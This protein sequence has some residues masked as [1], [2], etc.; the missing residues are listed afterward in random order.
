MPTRQQRVEQ[1][2]QIKQNI[3]LAKNWARY[4]TKYSIYIIAHGKLKVQVP[5]SGVVSLTD[6]SNN[7][8]D[9]YSIICRRVFILSSVEQLG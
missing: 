5:W 6:I 1:N 8:I 4:R 7:D 9:L 3:T 2:S